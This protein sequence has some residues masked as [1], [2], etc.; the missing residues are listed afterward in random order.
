MAWHGSDKRGNLESE[1]SLQEDRVEETTALEHRL[2]QLADD[3]WAVVTEAPA[4]DREA[5]HDYAVS[6]VRERLPVAAE[7][8][9]RLRASDAVAA[10]TAGGS[11]V[12]AF[13]YGLLLLPV[14]FFLLWI[15]PFIGVM[16]CAVG[17]GLLCWGLIVSLFGKLR[18]RP[19]PAESSA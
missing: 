6:L 1:R 15:F 12:Q 5:L 17:V 7:L 16:L 19:G 4:E 10:G 2:E 13:G 8:M 18:K 14:G 9:D 3:M 11:G